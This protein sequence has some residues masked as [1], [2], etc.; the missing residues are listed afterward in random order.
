MRKLPLDQIEEL[1]EE[2]VFHPSPCKRHRDRV[3]RSAVQATFR[4]KISR[5][6][7]AAGSAVV[8]L[9]G[10]TIFIMRMAA[11]AP[12]DEALPQSAAPSSAAPAE[13]PTSAAPEQQPAPAGS[14]GE[15][16]YRGSN[17]AQ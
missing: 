1:V 15:G 16:L 13:T 8:I 10:M 3:L 12:S 5:R 2:S 9:I 17:Q 11:P 7:I 6:A 4:H 14:L